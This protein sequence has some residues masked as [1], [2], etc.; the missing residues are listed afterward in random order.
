MRN[1]RIVISIILAGCLLTGLAMA[2]SQA[3]AEVKGE[4]PPMGPP[5]EMKQLEKMVGVWKVAGEMIMD[6]TNPE[7]MPFTA[8]AEFEYDLGGAVMEMEYTSEMMGTPYIGVSLTTWDRERQVW[9]D[10]WV[11]NLNCRQMIMTGHE[12]DGQRVM[13]GTD[14]YMG[15]EYLLRNTSYNMT[16]TSF[17]W[18]MEQSMDGGETWFTS[19]TATYTKQ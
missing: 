16:D 5:E 8:T 3:E 2:Q 19:M 17:D 11:D 14:I 4:M 10:S 9:Q 12:K 7:P 15:T 13:T 18:K 1:S 6:P